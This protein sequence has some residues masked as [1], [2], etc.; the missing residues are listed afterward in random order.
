MPF[1]FGQ[2]LECKETQKQIVKRINDILEERL[3]IPRWNGKHDP[4]DSLIRTILS[5]NTNDRNRDRAYQF[6][7]KKFPTWESVWRAGASE[8]SEAI[9][10]GGLANQKG[11]RIKG[12]LNWIKEK[13]GDFNLDFMCRMPTEEVFKT[14]LPLKGVGV[15]TLAVVLMFACGRDIFPVDTHVHRVCRKLGLVPNPSTAEKTFYSMQNLIP[16]GKSYSLHLNM[17]TFGRTICQARNPQC[18]RCF[19]FS[20]CVFEDKVVYAQSA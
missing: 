1:R 7:K 12:L 16:E 15:K 13:H 19:L 14:F 3:G 18:Y 10:V 8:I 6:L 11:R 9:K 2:I 5:Q 4:L 17:I 20:E